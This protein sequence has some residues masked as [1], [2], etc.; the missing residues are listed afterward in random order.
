MSG[1]LI[2]GLPSKGR[3]KEQVEAAVGQPFLDLFLQPAL[4][5]DGDDQG[6]LLGL[7]H[8]S[9]PEKA[10]QGRTTQPTAPAWAEPPSRASRPS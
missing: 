4:R 9:P 8:A 5:R 1:P 2:I 3:L 7:A 6:R 10:R